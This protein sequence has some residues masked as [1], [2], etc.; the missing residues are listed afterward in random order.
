[1]FGKIS[2]G[3]FVL[4]LCG[5]EYRISDNIK[6]KRWFKNFSVIQKPYIKE[7]NTPP[8]PSHFLFKK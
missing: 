1:M 6:L 7:A 4:R 8:P 5:Q 3:E 2:Y